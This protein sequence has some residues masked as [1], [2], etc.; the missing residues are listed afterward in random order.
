MRVDSGV[1]SRVGS[2]PPY[3]DVFGAVC[4]DWCLVSRDLCLDWCGLWYF[5]LRR[6]CY[7]EDGGQTCC[8][9]ASSSRYCGGF[10]FIVGGVRRVLAKTSFGFTN[11]LLEILELSLLDVDRL[12]S[13]KGC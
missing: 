1:L 4:G 6:L 5:F 10:C 9:R 2:R 3:N 12:A 8:T 13:E 7:G 11:A